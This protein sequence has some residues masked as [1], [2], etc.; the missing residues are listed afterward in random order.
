M[1]AAKKETGE[2][3]LLRL[4]E[5]KDKPSEGGA[6]SVAPGAAAPG[7]HVDGIAQSVKGLGLP[8]FNIPLFLAP[9]IGLLQGK[10]S[11][12]SPANLSFG[13]KDINNFLVI[14]VLIIS[15]F[16]ISTIVGGLRGKGKMTF[17]V[18]TKIAEDEP[19]GV[20]EPV[21]VAFYL[22]KISERNIFQPYEKKVAAQDSAPVPEEKRID[23]LTK[24]LKLVGIS[25]LETMDN[26]Y[27]MIEDTK[28][29]VT[30]F[31]SKGET[32]NSVTVKE[33]FVDQVILSFGDDELPMKL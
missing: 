29:G 19:I 22:E 31:L 14:V 15:A 6:S 8:P 30:Y 26:S 33:I 17:K 23:A 2:Q 9:I 13:L 4:I 21:D 1:V 20:P 12:G 28:T 25:W 11:G 10:G 24:D 32:V 27:V 5:E 16:F 7:A 3:K 18:S